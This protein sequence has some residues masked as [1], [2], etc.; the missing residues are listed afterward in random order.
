[1][2]DAATTFSYYGVPS[3]LNID[4]SEVKVRLILCKIR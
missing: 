4:I 2:T 3:L 1:M